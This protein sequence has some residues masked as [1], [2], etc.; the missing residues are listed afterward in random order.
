MTLGVLWILLRAGY[1]LRGIFVDFDSGYVGSNF[2][3]SGVVSTVVCPS[4]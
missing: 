2:G 4:I 1:G 3:E